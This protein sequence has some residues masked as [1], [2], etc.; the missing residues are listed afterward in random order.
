MKG[1]KRQTE[2]FW[3]RF[4]YFDCDHVFVTAPK[5]AIY[6]YLKYTNIL[7]Q[8][9][10]MRLCKS[11]PFIYLHTLQS[12]SFVCIVQGLQI[13]RLTIYLRHVSDIRLI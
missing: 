6:K 13:G 4:I 1:V 12:A 5:D 2:T 10:I 9:R 7:W 3:Q 8:Y 11:K